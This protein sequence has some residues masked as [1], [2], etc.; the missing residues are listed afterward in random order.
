MQGPTRTTKGSVFTDLLH[1]PDDAALMAF[2]ARL[3]HALER[4][5]AGFDTQAEAADAL[6]SL[7][8]SRGESAPDLRDRQRAPLEVLHRPPHQVLQ[9]GRAAHPRL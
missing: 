2:K 7:P 1:D 9:P 4:Y 8:R 3:L 5:V 6:G